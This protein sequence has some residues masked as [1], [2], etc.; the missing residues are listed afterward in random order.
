ML[1]VGPDYICNN[2]L[3]SE[4]HKC[5][6]SPVNADSLWTLIVNRMM[7]LILTGPTVQDVVDRIREKVNAK[8]HRQREQLAETEAALC[9]MRKRRSRLERVPGNDGGAESFGHHSDIR[10]ITN[11]IIVLECEARA[12]KRERETLDRIND[13]E[14][15][16]NNASDLDTYVHPAYLEY[17]ERILE[18]FLESVEVGR[19]TATLTFKMP[20]PTEAAP[21]GTLSEEI[22]MAS[23]ILQGSES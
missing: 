17:T 6:T 4:G 19:N 5:P 10:D 14:R 15:L 20:V 22:D 18:M 23:A 21:E 2:A 11:R 8:D 16:R 9:Q 3:Q 12:F 7:T 13:P 1:K